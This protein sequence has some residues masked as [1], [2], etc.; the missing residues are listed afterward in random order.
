MPV[1]VRI[2][3]ILVTPSCCAVFLDAPDKTFL[4]HVGRGVGM[5]ISMAIEN[6]RAPR[7]L[8]HD[9][10]MN[11][12]AGLGVRVERVVINGLRGD[13]FY[14]R[15][16]LREESERGTRLVEVDAR[17]S[18]CLALAAQAG[19]P[20]HV[21][22]SVLELVEDVRGALEAGEGADEPADA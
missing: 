13:T 11:V 4:I 17:P 15:L 20:I 8:S 3:R 21:E 5:A 22:E 14:A 16:F 12:L 19:A 10:I 18:D 7:P 9:L 2:R 6:V 1:A